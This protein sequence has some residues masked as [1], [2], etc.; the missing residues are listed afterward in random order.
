VVD[1]NRPNSEQLAD[2]ILVGDVEAH[3]FRN[4][5]RHRTHIE[6]ISL[7]NKLFLET[8]GLEFFPYSIDKQMFSFGVAF[9]SEDYPLVSDNQGNSQIISL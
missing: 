6:S 1:V 8:I 2:D 3:K 7:L 5:C 9:C 4:L